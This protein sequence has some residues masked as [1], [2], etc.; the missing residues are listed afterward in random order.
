MPTHN[1]RL[2]QRII[3]HLAAEDAKFRVFQIAAAPGE[4]ACATPPLLYGGSH[5][6]RLAALESWFAEWSALP[7]P[8]R[9][10]RNVARVKE[11]LEEL[12][13]LRVTGASQ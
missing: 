13:R 12:A 8:E 1:D 4:A 2:L 6:Q 7:E 3:E 9:G 10:T 5:Q 11:A